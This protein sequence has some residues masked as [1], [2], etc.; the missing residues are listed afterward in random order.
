MGVLNILF[1]YSFPLFHGNVKLR[2]KIPI[3]FF[4]VD[5]YFRGAVIQTKQMDKRNT[6]I[7]SIKA[8]R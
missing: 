7:T 1:I 8:A 2:R 4:Q 3:H 5:R 6:M